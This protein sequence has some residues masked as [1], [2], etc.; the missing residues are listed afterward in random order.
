MPLKS[1]S[2]VPKQPAHAATERYKP[3]R[4]RHPRARLCH[5]AVTLRRIAANGA[6]SSNLTPSEVGCM[7]SRA[8]HAAR[9]TGMGASLILRYSDVSTS[10]HREMSEDRQSTRL[11][12]NY[13]ASADAVIC[14]KTQNP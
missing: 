3:S 12:S 10:Q 13:V 14:L 1:A 11:N 8:H 4:I 5:G 7:P 2:L 6:E 9:S